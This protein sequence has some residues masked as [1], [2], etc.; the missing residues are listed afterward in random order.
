[1]LLKPDP[2]GDYD[3]KNVGG[4]ESGVLFDVGGDECSEGSRF[5]HRGR[6]HTDSG[7]S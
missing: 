1:M 3:Y 7:F 4:F 6:D 2:T 5:F